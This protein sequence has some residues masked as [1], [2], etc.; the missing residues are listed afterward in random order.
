MITHVAI[1]VDDGRVFSLPEPY[2][3]HN[4]I[5]IIAQVL[6]QQAHG[7]QGFLYEEGGTYRFVDR[8]EAVTLAVRDGQV[9]LPKRGDPQYEL[10]SEAVW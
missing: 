3:H 10:F 1:R 4:V 6:E 7:E 5:Y 8:R 2:R 9:S